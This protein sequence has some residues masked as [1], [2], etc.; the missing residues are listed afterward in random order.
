MHIFFIF[1]ASLLCAIGFILALPKVP[2]LKSAFIQR[3]IPALGGIAVGLAFFLV[4]LFFLWRES[5]FSKEGV[6]ILLASFLMLIFGIAD[7]RKEFS[8]GAKVC[9]QT[10][11]ALLLISFGV[12]TQ[13]IYIGV[14]L[15]TVVTLV[16]ILGVTNSFNHLDIIDGLAGTAAIISTAAFLFLAKL[17]AGPATFLLLVALLGSVCGFL[18]YNLPAAKIYLGNAGSHF[19][20]FVIAA[21]AI[22]ISYA[23]MDRKI[24]LVSPLL[25]LGLPILDTV[26]L[27][28]VRMKK[29]KLP[30]MK[31][32]DHIATRLLRMGLSPRRVLFLMGGWGLVCALAGIVISRLTNILALL[33]IIV[34]SAISVVVVSYA[35]RVAV[36]D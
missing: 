17:S 28:L 10:A 32:N 6:G 36:D 33:V 31:S 9:T 15:N 30:F 8:V 16:W 2:G 7:D 35:G 34:V 20:G 21:A 13:I 23:P 18:K 4:S 29:R 3:G 12:R 22:T 24:A 19:I 5:A 14:A 26:F 25:I 1:F 11:A 27:M